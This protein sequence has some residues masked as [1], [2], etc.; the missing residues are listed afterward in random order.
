MAPDRKHGTVGLGAP[1]TT[2]APALMVLAGE[3]SS[4][5]MA[6]CWQ[7][8]VRGERGALC[9][10]RCAARSQSRAAWHLSLSESQSF[11]WER[12]RQRLALLALSGP[13]WRTVHACGLL[14]TALSPGG[15]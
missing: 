11:I 13:N 8:G 12:G 1:A 6:G 2:F 5:S 10:A 14:K 3:S 15:P 4:R 7:G 9:G